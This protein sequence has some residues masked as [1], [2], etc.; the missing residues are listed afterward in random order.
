MGRRTKSKEERIGT[1]IPGMGHWKK[2]SRGKSGLRKVHISQV[3]LRALR[4]GS[5]TSKL[6]RASPIHSS[7]EGH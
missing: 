3:Q 5:L 4:K 1:L 2:V 7:Y 6:A